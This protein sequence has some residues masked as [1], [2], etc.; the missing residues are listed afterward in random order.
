VRTAKE[1]TGEASTSSASASPT[2]HKREPRSVEKKLCQGRRSILAGFS[3][4][5]LER[6]LVD[7][8]QLFHLQ[9]DTTVIREI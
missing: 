4:V 7:M 5:L 6:M 9:Y 2:K 3:S 1:D 8:I